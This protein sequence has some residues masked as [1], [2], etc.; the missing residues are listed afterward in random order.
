[1]T[2]F[3]IATSKLHSMLKAVSHAAAV[4]DVRYYLNGIRVEV[5]GERLIL[6]ATDGHRMAI[7]ECDLPDNPLPMAFTIKGDVKA[8][9]GYLGEQAKISKGAETQL[10]YAQGE[11]TMCE[12]RPGSEAPPRVQFEEPGHIELRTKHG[13]S[14]GLQTFYVTMP[15][16]DKY[17]DWRRVNP[18]A[19]AMKDLMKDAQGV[20]GDYMADAFKAAASF[21]KKYGGT[22][23]SV[24][25]NQQLV[26]ETVSPDGVDFRVVV[27]SMKI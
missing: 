25:N 7:A 4:K 1:M 12:Q 26:V 24:L 20:N 8:L 17:P 14:W 19:Q 13:I 18:S 23:I 2:T 27:M 21:S 15:S 6:V 16:T 9:I 11:Q 5:V 3:I 22:K 10:T